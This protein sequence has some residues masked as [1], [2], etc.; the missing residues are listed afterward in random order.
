MRISFCG[1]ASEVT[2]SCNLLETNGQKILVDCGMFQGSEF[3]EAKN[4]DSFPF[5]SAELNAVIITHAHLDH[6]GRLPLL[7]KRGFGGHIYATPATID[8]AKCVLED[9]CHVMAENN[10][11][12]GSPVLYNLQDVDIT[13]ERFKKVDYHE[14]ILLTS[15]SPSPSQGEE[16][17]IFEF[18]DA[19]HIFGSAFVVIEAEGK[20]VVFSG[21]IGN[22]EMPI[23]KE[24]EILP[25]KDI[26]VLICE[27][28]YGGR[29]HEHFSRRGEIIE[30]MVAHA[31]ERGGVLMIPIFAL[32]RTQ[33]LIYILN[34]LVDRQHRL[35]RVPIFL[36][37]PLAINATE[38][39]RHYPQYYDEEAKK[40]YEAGDDL[41]DFPGLTMC[42]L[43]EESKRIN[44]TPNPK[45]IIAGAGM[46]NGGRILHHAIRYLPNPNSTLL[47]IG[48]QA[49]N[50]LGRRILEGES[51]VQ[52]MGEEIRVR[53]RVQAIGALSA[54]GDQNKLVSWIGQSPKKVYLNHGEPEQ[55]NAL[56]V[57]LKKENSIEAIV[58]EKE[59]VVNF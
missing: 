24:T 34:D 29:L 53:A 6:V 20:R 43:R 4:N 47:F 35:P 1:A 54:H 15:P 44:H 27:S 57:R 23:L 55:A 16:K 26:D 46:M 8:L 17:F 9:A 49:G 21:D 50:T 37:S 18:Y 40:F 59:M 11:R 22:L 56:A 12:H 5:Q 42:N 14:K 28:T 10:R 13:M 52:I 48:Y 39:Y 32:E 41:F 33:E 58:V 2:G 7:V 30:N 36:D 31:V 19:G 38:V 45:I 25:K 3:N 51:P